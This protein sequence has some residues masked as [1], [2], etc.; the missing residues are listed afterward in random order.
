MNKNNI[1]SFTIQHN[2]TEGTVTLWMNG[3][4]HTWSHDKHTIAAIL[5]VI[6]YRLKTTDTDLLRHAAR[7]GVTLPTK[8]VE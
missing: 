2:E 4:K 5:R 8:P 1:L 6:E 3:E 7:Y